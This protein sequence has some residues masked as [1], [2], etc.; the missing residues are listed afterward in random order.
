MLAAA[1]ERLD[2]AAAADRA[3]LR[4]V[5]REIAALVARSEFF[6]ARLRWWAMRG[7]QLWA[8]TADR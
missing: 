5:E 4:L 8:E 1:R 3:D 6:A 7:R 2:S